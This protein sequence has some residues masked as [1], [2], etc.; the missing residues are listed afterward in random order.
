MPSSIE[1]FDTG[2]RPSTGPK[3]SS[4]TLSTGVNTAHQLRPDLCLYRPEH[5]A[6]IGVQDGEGGLQDGEGGS[7][8]KKRSKWLGRVVWPLVLLCVEVNTAADYSPL[9]NRGSSCHCENSPG[10][11]SVGARGQVAEYAAETFFH[12]HRCHVFSVSIWRQYVR[13]LLWDRAGVCMT[14][15]INYQE[16]PLKLVQFFSCVGQMSD[17][18]LGWDP[19]VTRISQEDATLQRRWELAVGNHGLAPHIR[20][21]ISERRVWDDPVER[22]CVEV[23]ESDLQSA[24]TSWVNQVAMKKPEPP[25]GVVSLLIGRCDF[26]H[27]SHAGRGTRGFIALHLAHDPTDDKFVYMKDSWRVDYADREGR[28]HESAPPP[29]VVIY[30]MLHEQG[31]INIPRILSGGDV[32]SRVA[33]TPLLQRTSNHRTLEDVR[34]RV[35]TRLILAD[36]GRKL[37]DYETSEELVRV[38]RDAIVGMSSIT[39]ARRSSSVALAHRDAWYKAGYLHRD[40]SPQNIIMVRNDAGLWTGTLIDWDLCKHK[41]ALINSA[42]N[43]SRSVS[44]DM[45]DLAIILKL[46]AFYQGTWEYLSALS[47]TYPKKPYGPSDDL[48]S[49]M[50]ILRK[51]AAKFHHSEESTFTAS[52]QPLQN[53]FRPYTAAIFDGGSQIAHPSRVRTIAEGW[54]PVILDPTKN[55]AGFISLIDDLTQLCADYYSKA[56][57]L[58]KIKAFYG[59][60]SREGSDDGLSTV[61]DFRFDH[62]TFIELFD[63]A[64]RSEGAWH[65][66]KTEDQ[67]PSDYHS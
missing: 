11:R 50:H 29:E 28:V 40:I 34:R 31:V 10:D 12:Q 48:E 55:S 23:A 8:Y 37:C 64:L 51:Y 17:V 58:D 1:V 62:D 18:Q 41:D 22:Y 21:R 6:L 25:R 43:H 63:K 42:S 27:R 32:Y 30:A 3:P 52:R 56:L 16:E 67:M 19:T 59:P 47:A 39:Y 35:H 15:K 36:I 2:D 33:G 20:Q 38:V 44:N 14:E 53:A 9:S 5:A 66:D 49:F 57:D 7:R 13:F 65:V 60:S 61:A 4:G 45:L 26:G 24:K 54:K 46:T